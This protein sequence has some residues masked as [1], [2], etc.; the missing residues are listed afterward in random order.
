MNN[1][2]FNLHNQLL[3]E[4]K[5]LWR[6]ESFY[7]NDCKGDKVAEKF[8]KKLAANKRKT[9]EEIRLMVSSKK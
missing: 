6:I 9:I 1:A 7:M 8:W 5:S 4:Q 2:Q 3:Q